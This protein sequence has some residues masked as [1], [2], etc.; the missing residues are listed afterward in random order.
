VAAR[1]FIGSFGITKKIKWYYEEGLNSS[2]VEAKFVFR[3]RKYSVEFD[4]LGMLQDIEVVTAWEEIP[5]PVGRAISAELDGA[6]SKYRVR[7]IQLQYTGQKEVLRSL[8]LDGPSAGPCTT[9][10]EI[11]VRGKKDSR[12]ALY[13]VT[14]NSEGKI[15]K[16]SKIVFKNTDNLEY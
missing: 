9:R 14:F 8:V 11:V 6:F 12:P 4:T 10:Y 2:S 7:K 16:I 13:E 1:E 5:D 3:D 15:E